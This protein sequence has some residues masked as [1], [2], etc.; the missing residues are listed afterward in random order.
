M[1]LFCPNNCPNVGI[2]P[3]LQFPHLPRTGP[4][5]LLSSFSPYFLHPT[6]FCVILYILFRWSGTPAFSQLVFCKY[7]CV[8]SCILDVSVERDVLHIHLLLCYL[9]FPLFPLTHTLKVCKPVM[10]SVR[11]VLKAV[12]EAKVLRQ[13]LYRIREPLPTRDWCVMA[14]FSLRTLILLLSPTF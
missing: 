5:L 11:Q 10:P 6:E 9:V 4:V 8:W 12:L 3:L 2:R 7:F 1:F 13:L 14:R